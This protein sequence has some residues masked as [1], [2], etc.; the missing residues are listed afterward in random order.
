MHSATVSS[1]SS[2]S[3]APSFV[4]VYGGNG[5]LGQAMV[6]SFRAAGW[7]TISVDFYENSSADHN[8]LLSHTNDWRTNTEAVTSSLQALASSLA[9][10]GAIAERPT[11]SSASAPAPYLSAV[12]S[13]AGA[14]KGSSISSPA[15]FES[16]DLMLSQNVLSSLSSAHIASLFL[17][18]SSLFLLT[19]ASAASSPSGTPSMIAY[20]LSKAAVHHLTLSLSAHDSELTARGTRV[21]CLLPVTI[22]T[23]KNR[24]VMRSA[25]YGDWTPVGEFARCAVRWAEETDAGKRAKDA[26]KARKGKDQDKPEG[27]AGEVR[28]VKHAEGGERGGGGIPTLVHGGFFEF[29]TSKNATSVQ[30]IDDPLALG[31]VVAQ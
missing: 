13:V 14:W 7:R 18:P 17:L 31:R 20:G 11:G 29:R 2:T 6:S 25:D 23:P 26:R 24:Q 27:K 22:D 8:I 5:S 12:V 15:L 3:S 10:D 16:T 9:D 21:A 28:R 30:L 19:G 1:S 4:L